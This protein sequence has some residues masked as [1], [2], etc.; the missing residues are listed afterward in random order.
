MKLLCLNL[1]GGQ[2]YKPLLEFIKQQKDVD[3][4]CFQEVMQSSVSKFSNKAKTDVY[5]DLSK[6]LKNYTGFLAT[7]I[8]SGFDLKE[9]VD[10]DLKFGQAT[11]VK[12]GIKVVSDETYFVY[13]QKGPVSF[14][15]IEKNTRRY[16]DIPRNM[17]CLVIDQGNK[18][19][20]IGNLHGFWM[21]VSKKDSPHR[22][23][24]SNKIREIF[25]QHPGPKILCGDFN[26]R[27]ETK[28]MKILEENMRN[29]IVEYGI[30]S[31]RSKHHRRTNKYADYIMVSADIKINRFEAMDAH[32]SDHLPLLLEFSV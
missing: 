24:Q 25:D 6:I 8:L 18:K 9:K 13:G 3:I 15:K 29:L 26:L 11:F 20:L 32:V 16:L 14:W 7:P 10:F 1:W 5:N 17:Q 27:P 21:P 4:F 2:V 31:T 22:I 30:E 19:I 23:R 28:S 12:K